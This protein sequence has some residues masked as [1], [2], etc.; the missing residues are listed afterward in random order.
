MTA[1][2]WHICVFPVL[3][4]PKISVIDPVS[5]P[6]PRSLSSS[7]DP[8]VTVM[9]SDRRWWY[10]VA[11]ENPIGTSF[12]AMGEVSVVVMVYLLEETCLPLPLKF[13]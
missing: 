4:S 5:R 2:V 13:L 3:N 11:V 6:P 12:A 10:S 9:I 7:E 1:S 8:V